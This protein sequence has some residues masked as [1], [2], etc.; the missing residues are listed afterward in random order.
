MPVG[1]ITP[2]A[3]ADVAP[4]AVDLAAAVTS[5]TLV[6]APVPLAGAGPHPLTAELAAI[7][8]PTPHCGG[9]MFFTRGRYRVI[10]PAAPRGRVLVIPV[11]CIELSRTQMGRT[12]ARTRRSP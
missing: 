7:I 10:E 9:S 11:P 5:D 1:A 8:D 4:A 2:K 3:P 6:A 12:Q